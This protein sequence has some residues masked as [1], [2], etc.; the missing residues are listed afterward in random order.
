M[1]KKAQRRNCSYEFQQ[2]IQG[3]QKSAG[4]LPKS[5]IGVTNT[6]SD[7]ITPL[8]TSHESST[9]APIYSIP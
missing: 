9:L 4:S 6:S 8:E 7:G 3:E 2:C 1:R 5:N